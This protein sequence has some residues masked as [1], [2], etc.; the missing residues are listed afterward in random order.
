[1]PLLSPKPLLLLPSGPLLVQA[2]EFGAFGA[3]DAPVEL[4]RH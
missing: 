2:P 4:L 3:R 1:V